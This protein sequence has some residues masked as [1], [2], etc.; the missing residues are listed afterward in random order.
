MTIGRNKILRAVNVIFN[1]VDLIGKGVLGHVIYTYKV[2]MLV[3]LAVRESIFYQ[4]QGLRTVFRVVS[5]QIYF[6]GY[7]ALPIVS[8]L[9]IASGAIV[10]LQSSAQLN[11]LGGAERIGDLLVAVIV[12]EVGPLLTA[13]I[14]IAR[15]G[16]AVASELG[17]MKVNREID[18]LEVMGINPLSYIVF[19]R[20]VGGII[21]VVCLAFYFSFISLFGGYFITRLLHDLPFAFYIDSLSQAFAKE[22]VLL[23]AVKNV[24]SGAIIFAVCCYQG[25]SVG[26][27]S[28]EVPQ[29][30]TAAVMKSIIYVIGFNV[31]VTIFY[32]LNELIKIG[33]I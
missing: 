12:R 27:S 24:F 20:V 14:V 10:I 23:F 21:S 31:I 16:T 28:H 7:Q 2:F 1:Q 8:V 19:P 4:V 11:F 33:V 30:T 18:A 26:Q 32:Y 5:A 3:Y 22:D 29:A 15:S 25:L 13:L 9:A 17:N 6:T